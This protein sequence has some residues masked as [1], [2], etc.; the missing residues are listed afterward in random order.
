MTCEEE[1]DRRAGLK[2]WARDA[3]ARS[4]ACAAQAVSAAVS[5]AAI[6]DQVDRI[7]GRVAER[8]PEYAKPLRAIVDAAAS[9]RAAIAGWQR[10]CPAGQ[11]IPGTRDEPDAAAVTGLHGQLRDLAIIYDGDRTAGALQEAV[12]Q[13]AF[14]AGLMLHDAVGLTAEPDVRWRIEAAADDLDEMIRVL[15]SAL[16]N[17]ADWLPRHQPQAPD[18]PASP[19]GDR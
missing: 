9:Q 4:A 7:I 6:G 15:R 1:R 8:N 12:V 17:C 10:R 5:A 2:A 18:D 3:R 16:F 11:L 14:R 19:A 13:G